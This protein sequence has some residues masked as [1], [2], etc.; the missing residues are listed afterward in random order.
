MKTKKYICKVEA[1]CFYKQDVIAKDHV[2]VRPCFSAAGVVMPPS[3]I[4]AKAY[5]STA[6]AVQG[7]LGAV[8]ATTESSHMNKERYLSWFR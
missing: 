2:T 8:Y 4:F 6:Y 7:P 1:K 5:P 3:I